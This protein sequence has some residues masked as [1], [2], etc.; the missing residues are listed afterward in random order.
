[1]TMW[2]THGH[3]RGSRI[4]KHVAREIWTSWNREYVN[5]YSPNQKPQPGYRGVGEFGVLLRDVVLEAMQQ[6]RSAIS[7]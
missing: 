7:V 6:E 3:E 1:M 4:L 5:V 2:Y